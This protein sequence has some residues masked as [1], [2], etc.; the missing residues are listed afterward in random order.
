MFLKAQLSLRLLLLLAC[1]ILLNTLGTLHVS[2]HP[3]D[4]EAVA[5]LVMSYG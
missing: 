2:A 1:F 5:Q 4:E 3:G